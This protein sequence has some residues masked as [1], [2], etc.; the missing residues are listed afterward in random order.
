MHYI[1]V[2]MYCFWLSRCYVTILPFVKINK[3]KDVK[4][5]CCQAQ[6]PFALNF[7]FYLLVLVFWRLWYNIAVLFKN[8]DLCILE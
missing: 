4:D 6:F 2:S 5:I 3:D 8:Q 7:N 1:V